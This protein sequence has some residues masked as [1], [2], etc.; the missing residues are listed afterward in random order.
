MFVVRFRVE[1]RPER[2]DD[3]VAALE[4]VVPPS[5]AIPGVLSFDIGR[6]VTDRN[7]FIA[8]E[9]YEDT[10]ARDQQTG[11]PEVA[12]LTSILPDSLGAAPQAILYHVASFE[13]AAS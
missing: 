7:V 4:T 12:R 10:A 6:D 11:L 8:T 9:V 1:A 5:R 2:A 3:L 13:P